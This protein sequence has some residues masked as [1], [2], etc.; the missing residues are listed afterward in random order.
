MILVAFIVVAILGTVTGCVN[1][2][3]PWTKYD[4]D[5]FDRCVA[6]E[7]RRIDNAGN[8]GLVA[9]PMSLADDLK[10]MSVC[11]QRTIERANR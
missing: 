2:N 3:S 1:L 7:Q 9:D 8:Y 5:Y 6:E 11:R 4:P 10:I